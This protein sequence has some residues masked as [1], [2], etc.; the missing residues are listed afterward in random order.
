MLVETH[1]LSRV[2]VGQR[3]E[4][5]GLDDAE[6]GR[7]AADAERE[8]GNHDRGIAGSAP[9]LPYRQPEI[10]PERVAGAQRI[11]LID[12]LAGPGDVAEL[13]A[14]RDARLGGRQAGA[15]VAIGQHLEMGFELETGLLVQAPARPSVA[16]PRRP[17]DQEVAHVSAAPPGAAAG[18]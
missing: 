7:G 4:Q 9:D 13:A 5:Y 17:C 3:R 14:R 11:E 12:L 1:Q 10:L 2:V 8:R 6:D 15:D 16:E 18:R